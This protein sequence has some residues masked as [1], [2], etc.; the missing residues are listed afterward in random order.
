MEN[1]V[2]NV[3]HQRRSTRSFDKQRTLEAEK[4]D[5]ILEASLW[6]PNGMGY[7][8]PVIVAVQDAGLVEQLRALNAQVRG[9]KSDPYYGASTFV[10][11]FGKKAWQHHVEDCSLA[12]G[13]MMLAAESIGVASC[14]I[15]ENTDVFELPE[16]R[17]LKDLFGIEEGYECVGALALG[18]AAKAGRAARRKEDR[19]RRF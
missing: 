8:D 1:S 16:G 5:T 19:I 6:A 18:Y 2:L 4:L 17:V 3:I 12:L 7:Q 10:F 9:V 11:V 14:W 13:T 15:D